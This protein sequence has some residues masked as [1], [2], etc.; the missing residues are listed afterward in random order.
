MP[1]HQKDLRLILFLVFTANITAHLFVFR[2]AVGKV[3]AGHY[4]FAAYYGATQVIKEGLG[5]DLYQYET[6]LRIQ[7][8]FSPDRKRPLLFN[9]PAFEALIYLPFGYVSFG[10]AYILWS[11]LN[12]AILLMIPLAL[13]PY[14]PNLM[15]SLR[16]NLIMMGCLSFFPVFVTVLQGQDSILLL[17]TY[18]LLFVSL[19]SGHDF[20]AGFF[21]GLGAFRF[22]LTMPFVLAFVFLRRWKLL[23]GFLTTSGALALVWLSITGWQG[24]LKYLQLL[25]TMNQGARS[26]VSGSDPYAL[27]PDVMPNLRGFLHTTLA[28]R[29]PEIYITVAVVGVSALLISWSIAKWMSRAG[30]G[31]SGLNLPFALHCT[32][33]ILASYHLHL[34][35]VTL[36]LLP[37]LLVADD[38]ATTRVSRG[39]LRVALA[40]TM[41]ILFLSP[42]YMG[43]ML[44]GRTNWLALLILAFALMISAVNSSAGSAARLFAAG[45]QRSRPRFS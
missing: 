9:H 24:G 6:Q 27:R 1:F 41:L 44:L 39:H 19:K 36:L 34:H 30:S 16:R 17:L 38:L 26:T 23:L 20:R 35:D 13:L 43:A 21:L 8:Q 12:L 14:I 7:Q 37:I 4:D 22:Q 18:T 33:A 42:V 25:W 28:G 31:E 11:L 3:L 15:G 2:L 5:K 10:N 32:V 29:V 40:A 45:G